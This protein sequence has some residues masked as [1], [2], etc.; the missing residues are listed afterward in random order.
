LR[1]NYHEEQHMELVLA[2]FGGIATFAIVA[3]VIARSAKN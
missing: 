2:V 1:S 3:L